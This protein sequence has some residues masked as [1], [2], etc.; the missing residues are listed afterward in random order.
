MTVQQVFDVSQTHGILMRP[1]NSLR[2][3]SDDCRWSS[4]YASAQREQPYEGRFP[5]VKDQL[6]VLHRNGPVELERFDGD[7]PYRV[8]VPAGGIHLFPG[9]IPFGVRLMGVLDTLHV[10]LRRPMIE[11]VAAEMI[12][13]DPA[14]LEIPADIIG[15]DP[16]LNGLLESVSQALADKDYAS[17]IYVDYMARAIASH[18][19]RR[20]SVARMRQ[21]GRQDIGPDLTRAIEFMHAHI[22][23]SISLG[24]VAQAAGRSTSHLA[25]QFREKFGQPPHSYLIGIRLELAKRMLEKTNEPI[26]NIALDCGFTHQEHLTRFFRR[27]YETTPAACRRNSR[28]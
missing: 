11:E 24:D 9:G 23:R 25:R 26:A 1:E 17:A 7:H 19:I 2:I 12:D 10:Y 4:L 20:H 27:R 5:A 8:T 13:G 15:P 16:V 14:G 18:L 22:D 28:N 3:S 21:D 6:L